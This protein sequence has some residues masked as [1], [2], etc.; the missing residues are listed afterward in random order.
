MYFAKSFAEAKKLIAADSL[1]NIPKVQE[2]L[3]PFCVVPAKKEMI[4]SLQNYDIY[5]KADALIKEKQFR[6]ILPL[7]PN[8]IFLTSEEVHKKI[9]NLAEAL[10]AKLRKADR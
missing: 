3:K 5:L 8:T 10:I 9:C 6:S 2:L 7:R 4:H 1:R